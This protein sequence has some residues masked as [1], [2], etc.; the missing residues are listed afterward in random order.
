MGTAPSVSTGKIW[1][2]YGLDKFDLTS[3]LSFNLGSLQ[4]YEVVL[5]LTAVFL[6][7]RA[8]WAGPR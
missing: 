1:G 7:S 4:I 2:I 5:V 3:Q 8:V 6:A